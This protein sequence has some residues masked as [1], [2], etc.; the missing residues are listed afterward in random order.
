[1]AGVHRLTACVTIVLIYWTSRIELT[2]MRFCEYVL[3]VSFHDLL[4][5]LTADLSH[6]T[7]NIIV[8]VLHPGPSRPLRCRCQWSSSHTDTA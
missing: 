3:D 5:H 1:V 2:E 6:F 7:G 4:G 8:A